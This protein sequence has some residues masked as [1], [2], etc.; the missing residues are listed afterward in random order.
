MLWRLDMTVSRQILALSVRPKADMAK[1]GL[2]ISTS[3][4]EKSWSPSGSMCRE[5]SSMCP[6]V[7]SP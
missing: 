7:F 4:Q 2:M 6:S 3:E 1:P 5:N